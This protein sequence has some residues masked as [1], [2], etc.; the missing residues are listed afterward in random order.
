MRYR[1]QLAV[2]VAENVR[3]RA[4]LINHRA[5]LHS[6]SSRPCET[7]RQSAAA[8]GISVPDKCARGSLDAAAL[9]EVVDREAREGSECES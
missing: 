3:L 6:G 1:T 5:D 4:A 8:L 9:L 2:L 7:C